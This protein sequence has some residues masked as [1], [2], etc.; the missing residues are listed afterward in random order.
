MW[1]ENFLHG[2]QQCTVLNGVS[3]TWINVISGVPQ[4]T[5]LGPILFN[6]FI[7]DAVNQI[8][9][10]GTLKLYADDSKLY[11]IITGPTDIQS[12]QRDLQALEQWTTL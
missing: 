6:L 4:G 9:P 3:S 1:L 2:T 11:R 5:I 10:G 12:Q 8:S 7:N